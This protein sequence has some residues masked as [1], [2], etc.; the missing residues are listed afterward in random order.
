MHFS[1]NICL[2]CEVPGDA[3]CWSEFA[4]ENHDIL[5]YSVNTASRGDPSSEHD[6]ALV[7]AP[8][9]AVDRSQAVH[10]IAL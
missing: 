9:V 4:N 10:G 8:A 6:L 2:T 1:H 3:A 5:N 7:G